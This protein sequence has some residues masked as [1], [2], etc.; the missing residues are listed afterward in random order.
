MDRICVACCF[1]CAGDFDFF[2]I[3]LLKIHKN[4]SSTVFLIL[5]YIPIPIFQ[6]F[7]IFLLIELS[8]IIDLMLLE[9]F[10]FFHSK[11]IN[12]FLLQ[13]I[14]NSVY[15]IQ[16]F[17]DN[18]SLTIMLGLFVFLSVAVGCINYILFFCYSL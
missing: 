5:V 2:G 15:S 3:F 8:L 17:P 9:L 12:F 13:I 18:H 10:D 4:F 1:Y 6:I 7:R 11:Q 14:L 16:F